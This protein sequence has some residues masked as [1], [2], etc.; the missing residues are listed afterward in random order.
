MRKASVIVA[1]SSFGTEGQRSGN[2]VAHLH[3]VG[4]CEHVSPFACRERLL[5]LGEHVGH[6]FECKA[7]L[8][9]IDELSDQRDILARKAVIRSQVAPLGGRWLRR[10]WDCDGN[11]REPVDLV[12]IVWVAGVDG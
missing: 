6:L 4:E 1:T 2:P 5:I 7:K 9:R 12:E 8:V 10:G 11:D 3:P